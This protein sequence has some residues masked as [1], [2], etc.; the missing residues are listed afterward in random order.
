MGSCV[1]QALRF[2]PTPRDAGGGVM[3]CL[4]C[5]DWRCMTCAHPEAQ[6]SRHLAQHGLLAK[7]LQGWNLC[8]TASRG[9]WCPVLASLVM[10][11]HLGSEFVS[12]CGWTAMLPGIVGSVGCLW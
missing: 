8:H 1:R 9:V 7:G 10:R 2:D 5:L 3:P 11:S 12:C 6:S 4:R